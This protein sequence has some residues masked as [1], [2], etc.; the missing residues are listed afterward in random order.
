MG[1]CV[2]SGGNLLVTVWRVVVICYWLLCG[3][4]WHFVI[5]YCVASGGILLATFQDKLSV[6]LQDA[7]FPEIYIR[8]Y[9]LHVKC[10]STP[11]HL[12][13]SKS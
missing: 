10:F 4:W 1:Y 12:L 8:D 3:E 9:M 5:G 6:F 11:V 7:C 13:L 2:G